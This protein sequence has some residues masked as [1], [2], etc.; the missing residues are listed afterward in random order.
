MKPDKHKIKRQRIRFDLR[1]VASWIEPGSK[2]LGLGCGEGEL[3]YYLKNNKQAA[4]TGIEI[5]EE[6]AAVCI[7]KG[8]TVLQG[9]INEEVDDY[10]DKAF[11]Y[12]ILSQTLQQIYQPAELIHSILRIGKKGIVSFPNF[13]HWRIRF[14][15]LFKGCAPISRQ[16]PYQW[17]N[18][19]NIRVMTIQDFRHFTK[20]AGF[21]ITKE[22]AI[23]THNRNR[24][25]NI[26][27]L[28]PNWR[29]TYG[30]F[31]IE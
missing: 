22:V 5:K 23:N 11:D 3:L 25:G 9:D 30:I 28:F 2:V 10:P 26:T 12:V 29:A 31:M 18:T 17:H 24:S 13:S 14:Q 27:R 4:C 19:P 8:L 20:E 15:L 16:L 7:A 1:V 6:R 21:K